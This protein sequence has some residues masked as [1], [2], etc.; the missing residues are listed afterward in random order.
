MKT[1]RLS[2]VH[3][4]LK[5]FKHKGLMITPIRGKKNIQKP[6]FKGVPYTE[7]LPLVYRNK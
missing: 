2:T 3:C 7:S 6:I 4:R 5:K 1:F